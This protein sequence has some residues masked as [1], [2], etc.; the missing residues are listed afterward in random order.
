VHAGG[1]LVSLARH[2][3]EAVAMGE[4]AAVAIDR[5]RLGQ[6]DAAPTSGPV[7]TLAQIATAYHEHAARA[8]SRTRPAAE[9]VADDAEVQLALSAAEARA[10]AARCFSCGTC[11]HCDT[12]V[13]VCPDLAVRPA[14]GGYEVLTDWCKGCGLCVRECPTGSMLMVEERR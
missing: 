4:R 1:D 5:Q 14:D 9:R 2:V 12:C 7:V 10:E 13:V 6:A 8:P 3:T 11:V